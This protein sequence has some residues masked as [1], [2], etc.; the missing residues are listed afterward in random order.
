[1][2]DSELLSKRF[3]ELIRRAEGGLYYTFTE[4]LGLSELSVL[5]MVLQKMPIS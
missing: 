4:F 3:T 5:K 1:M 2:S